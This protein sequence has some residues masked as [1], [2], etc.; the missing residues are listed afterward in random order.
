MSRHG[1]SRLKVEYGDVVDIFMRYWTSYGGWREF[2]VSPFVH[3]AIFITVLSSGYWLSSAWYATALS[4]LPNLLGFGVSGYAIWI[5]W[6]DEKLRNA[7]ISLKEDGKPSDYE[8]VSAV[9]AHFGLVQV[10]ALLSALICSALD[11][12]LSPKS[13]LAHGLAL[14]SLSP[15]WFSY[16]K[17]I[18]AGAGYFLFV[19]AIVTTFET[20]L[21]LFRLATWFQKMTEKR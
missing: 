15:N 5:G 3:L 8:R 18:G 13:M 14:V 4:V 9:F 7:L 21:A 2:V 1:E 11:Y 19:Y 20:T 6:G 17:P 12:E 10:V 16:L